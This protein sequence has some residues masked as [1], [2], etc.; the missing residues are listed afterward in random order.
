MH[1]KIQARLLY[2]PE[3]LHDAPL[4]VFKAFLRALRKPEFMDMARIFWRDLKRDRTVNR[5]RRFGQACVLADEMDADI[6]HV[7]VHFLHTPGSVVRY[8]CALTR[9]SYSFSAHAKDIWTIP[10][11]EK[12]EK[13]EDSLW[14]VTCTKDGLA[15]LQR[16]A[17]SSA[18]HRVQLVYHGLDIGRFPAPPPSRS[19]ADGRHHNQ[20]LHLVTVGRAVEKKG[21]DVL[22]DALALLPKDL[23]WKLTHIG[24]GP[25]LDKLK[26]RADDMQLSDRMRWLGSLPQDRVIEAL[27]EAD[28]FVLPSKLGTDGDRDGLPN[29]LMEAATQALPLV[30]TRFAA[31]PEFI[32]DQVE[33]L[34]V[35]PGD[36]QG[37]AKALSSLI[38][39]PSL[40][41]ALG[42]S[43]RERVVSAFSFESGIA[44]IDA[45][46]EQ[47]L[48]QSRSK[49]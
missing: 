30:S 4:R 5:L 3:Y 34:L 44:R 17:G 32:R 8:M 23:H 12:R 2:L 43:A 41:H 9:R 45:L 46:L 27:R 47:A 20:P 14:G 16:A 13:I 7:H 6:R 15:E 49:Q 1:K 33:G 31:V 36:P 40:R 42:Q 21:F 11:W 25:L 10:D 24:S 29:V 35:A 22:L 19:V 37:L 48:A 28:V 18:G 26:Q 38:T 39:E